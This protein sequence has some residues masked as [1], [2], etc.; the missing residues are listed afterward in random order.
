M[1]FWIK[2]NIKIKKK[3]LK[4]GQSHIRSMKMVL[5]PLI[6]QRLLFE[7]NI[8]IS[9]YRTQMLHVYMWVHILRDLLGVLWRNWPKSGLRFFFT[10]D[11]TTVGFSIRHS[12]R[13][14][15]CGGSATPWLICVE[16][17][18][19]PLTPIPPP[20]N[21]GHPTPA[22]TPSPIPK[23]R[24]F[25]IPTIHFSSE[26]FLS[27]PHTQTNHTVSLF[28][29]R[30]GKQIFSRP[31]ICIPPT[32]VKISPGRMKKKGINKRRLKKFIHFER[33]RGRGRTRSNVV[34][35]VEILRACA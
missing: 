3:P 32:G 2:K 12:V 17:H 31:K 25:T 23:E 4:R 22:I 11:V 30:A 6:I 14:D 34:V 21:N 20:W 29:F 9:P 27:T 33:G 1:K 26:T 19:P 15:P 16:T 24:Y 7:R 5:C 28:S 18:H 13:N 35:F 8:W 10:S